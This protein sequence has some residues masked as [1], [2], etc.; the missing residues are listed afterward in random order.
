MAEYTLHRQ[1]YTNERLVMGPHSYG[2]PLIATYPGDTSWVRVGSYVSIAVDVVLM[3]GGN[4][5]VDWITTYP[6]RALFDMPGAYA[7]GHPTT[8]GDLTIGND[9]WIGRGARVLS[10]VTIGDGAVIAG[11]SVVTKD[12]RP[13]AIVAGNPAREI[14]RR[15]ADEEVEALLAIAW[16]NWP[17]EKVLAA[18]PELCSENI[19]PFIERHRAPSP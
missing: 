10:G 11:Y 8:K 15:F 16:W 17:L 18:V 6:F 1:A 19:G 9:V 13:Y 14:R 7:D 5:R 4:H 2:E 3:D 12:V